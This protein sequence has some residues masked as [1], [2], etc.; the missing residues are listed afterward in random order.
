MD[1]YARSRC[2]TLHMDRLTL[3]VVVV[4]LAVGCNRKSGLAVPACDARGA[5]SLAARAAISN[6]DPTAIGPVDA[7]GVPV[8]CSTCMADPGGDTS[9]IGHSSSGPPP[10][11]ACVGRWADEGEMT[12]SDVHALG[13]D[14][15]P[16]LARF[17]GD[18]AAP[19]RWDLP[20]VEARSRLRVHIERTGKATVVRWRTL[21]A[22]MDD[23]CRFDDYAVAEV[24]V[25]LATDDGR[26]LGGLAIP[27]PRNRALRTVGPS[28]GISLS[29]QSDNPSILVRGDASSLRGTL[30]FDAPTDGRAFLHIELSI[31][32]AH[33]RSAQSRMAVKITQGVAP[34]GGRFKVLRTLEALPPDGCG[35]KQTLREAR[36]SDASCRE[37]RFELPGCCDS[38]DNS[39]RTDAGTL[40]PD[41]DA[42]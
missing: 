29:G 26:L 6:H 10:F 31:E 15:E 20:C 4:T 25:Q 32:P 42:G 39:E 5:P 28:P 11:T 41:E 17:E 21:D 12:L 18:Y 40:H 24:K 27:T 19:V 14:L 23:E 33:E 22:G 38:N 9:D 35:L 7:P 2:H 37:P 8:L 30:A 34:P 3:V 1:G 16:E 36:G 13:F